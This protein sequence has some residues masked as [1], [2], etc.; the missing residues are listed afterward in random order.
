MKNRRFWIYGILLMVLVV[1]L[2]TAAFRPLA[3]ARRKTVVVELFTSEGCSSCP[4]ADALLSRLGTERSSNGAEIIP[5]GFH[6]DYWDLQG[7][8]DR[9]S[10]HDYTQRQEQ[11]VQ[12]FHLDSPYT[13]EMV[14]DGRTEFVGNDSGR[15]QSAIG[16][17]ATREPGAQIEL[18]W[19]S[20]ERLKVS[21][22]TGPG[23]RAE[24]RLA[25]TENNLST[26]VGAG[27]NGGRV[28]HHSAVVRVFRVLGRLQQGKFEMQVPVKAEK[29]WKIE[30]L[31]IVALVQ[32]A[33]SGAIE[34][35]ASIPWTASLPGGK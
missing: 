35:A 12:Q 2:G 9:F 22:A 30:N 3:P 15:A 19:A 27:E 8:H 28:L 31:H 13:P 18:S 20:P 16:E 23:I 11:Y 24:V 34:G 14:V 33:P 21:V 10:S 1:L 17:A 6:V 26:E 5:L 25:V 32:S 4:P 29:D 7:W